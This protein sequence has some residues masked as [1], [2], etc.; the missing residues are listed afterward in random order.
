MKDFLTTELSYEQ[1]LKEARDSVAAGLDEVHK[2]MLE[3]ADGAP[4]TLSGQL[5][6]LLVRKGKRIRSTF[7]FLLADSG[8]NCQSGAYR[9]RCRRHRTHPP[10][11]PGP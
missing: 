2:V 4:G 3:V 5:N 10:G 9:P 8:R 11:L 7:L 1:V 6:S